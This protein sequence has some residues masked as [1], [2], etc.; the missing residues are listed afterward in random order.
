MHLLTGHGIFN[1]Y[2]H[3]IGKESHISCWDCGNDLDDAE[4]V[5]FKCSKWMVERTA[6]KSEVGL[7]WKMGI[8][9]LWLRFTVFCTRSMKS[10]QL[11]QREMEMRSRLVKGRRG[12][13]EFGSGR[14]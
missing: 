1:Y 9:R 14:S 12:R 6:L 13:A 7:E 8:D 10:R 2:R 4:H 11:K 3:R 5:C